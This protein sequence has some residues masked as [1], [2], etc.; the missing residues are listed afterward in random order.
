[1]RTSVRS[2]GLVGLLLFL[3]AAFTPLPSLLAR[4]LAVAAAPGPAD[5][6]VVL[7]AGVTE[8]GI[9]GG[10]SLRRAVTGILLA[11]QGLAPLLVLLG[12][13]FGGS[14]PEAKVRERLARDLGVDPGRILTVQDAWTT[15][16]E[17]EK[18]RA[19]L[20]PRGARRILL[21]T[22]SQHLVRAI[23]L[24][25]RQ[26][27]EVLPVV[28]DEESDWPRSPEGRLKLA[29]RVSQ[30]IVARAYHRVAGYL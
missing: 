7:G 30:E 1:M 13:S 9:L 23:P 20:A 25:A 28:A 24:F 15:R 11:R 12:P 29:R 22:D 27:F 6:V 16:E 5:A 18:S 2:V 4:H 10:A 3:A 8:D 17:A 19:L 21:V 26:G 14:P